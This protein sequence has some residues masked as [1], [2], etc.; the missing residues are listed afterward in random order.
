MQHSRVC[1]LACQN[2]ILIYP[3]LER[4]AKEIETNGGGSID[5]RLEDKE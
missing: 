2:H 1:S 5:I 4:E 3:K